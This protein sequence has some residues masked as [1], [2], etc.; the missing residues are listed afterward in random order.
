M[1][2]EG[3]VGVR[4]ECSCP[5]PGKTKCEWKNYTRRYLGS[6]AGSDDSGRIQ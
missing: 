3:E 2:V 6:P 5:L 1:S 4:L